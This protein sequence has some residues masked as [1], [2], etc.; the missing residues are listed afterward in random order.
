M[1]KDSNFEIFSFEPNFNLIQD[2]A[3]NNPKVHIYNKAVWTK[4]EKTNQQNHKI[5]RTC[6]TG[7]TKRGGQGS[8]VS[9]QYGPQKASNVWDS[10]KDR[11]LAPSDNALPTSDSYLQTPTYFEN[12]P[13]QVL[14]TQR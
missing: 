4:D 12:R 6:L 3:R 1:L 2:Y 11:L 5:Q 10:Q 14:R 9:V 8:H 7:N 13:L